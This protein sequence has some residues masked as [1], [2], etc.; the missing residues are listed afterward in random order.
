[1]NFHSENAVKFIVYIEIQKHV[2]ILWKNAY[3]QERMKRR[4]PRTTSE[5]PQTRERILIFDIIRLLCIVIIVYDHSRFVDIPWFNQ[6]FFAAGYGPFNIYSS[7]LQGYAVYGMILISGVVLEY[8]YQGLEKF[9]RYL[10]FLFRRFIRLYPA[11]W[12]SLI[13]GLIAFPKVWQNSIPSL[14]FEF[15]GFFVVLGKGPGNINIM[16]WFI[17]TI[18]SLYVLFPWFSKIIR[19][20]GLGALVGFWLLS[21]GLR[22]L[23][24]TYNL[25]PI[26]LFWRWF[27]LCN[28]FE[29]CLGIYIVQNGLYPKTTNTSPIIK[30]LSDLSYYVF[31]FHTL[32]NFYILDNLYPA[33]L[34]YVDLTLALNNPVVADILVYLQTNFAIIVVSWTVMK[35]DTRLRSWV[36]QRHRIRN[37]LSAQ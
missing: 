18:V 5:Q 28:A 25:V 11:F 32:V 27:P 36:M 10:Q 7:G 12:M 22:Y 35:M 30:E 33:P 9:H 6:L 31:I 19:R 2:F 17:A 23:I 4:K 3:K 26:N 24:L 34:G 8:N 37:F 20:Y 29:F 14:L 16:G 1:M 13:L 15:T 21:W